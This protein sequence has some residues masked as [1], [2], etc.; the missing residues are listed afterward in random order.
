MIFV[1]DEVF[2]ADLNS[3]QK[4]SGYC[5]FNAN[6]RKIPLRGKYS[7]T[8]TILERMEKVERGVR[9]FR[10]CL[11]KNAVRL[12]GDICRGMAEREN[13]WGKEKTEDMAGGWQC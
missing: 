11:R 13:V 3:G 7:L 1:C 2:Y 12:A 9:K 4:I 5:S 8:I 6:Q 10:T